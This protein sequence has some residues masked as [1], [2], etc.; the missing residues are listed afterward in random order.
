MVRGGVK[1]RSQ[2]RDWLALVPHGAAYQVNGTG[3]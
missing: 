2:A 3:P 1:D